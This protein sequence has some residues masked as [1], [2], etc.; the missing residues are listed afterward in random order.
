MSLRVSDIEKEKNVER[1]PEF[2]GPSNDEEVNW[3]FLDFLKNGMD[4]MPENYMA[5]IK[6]IHGILEDCPNLTRKQKL[7]YCNIERYFIKK[8]LEVFSKKS[9][10]FY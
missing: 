6:K 2:I 8:Y 7:E 4:N 1:V 9:R 3:R 10:L 5:I